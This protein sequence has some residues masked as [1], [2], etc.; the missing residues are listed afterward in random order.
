MAAALVVTDE[1]ALPIRAVGDLAAAADVSREEVA[2]I[3]QCASLGELLLLVSS[4]PPSA[5]LFVRPET[6]S[7]CV[8][9]MHEQMLFLFFPCLCLHVRNS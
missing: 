3:T 6:G 2:V 1:V 8:E 7:S 5:A 9:K 4:P